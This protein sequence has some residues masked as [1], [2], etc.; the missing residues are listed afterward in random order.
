MQFDKSAFILHSKPTQSFGAFGLQVNVLLFLHFQIWRKRSKL[1]AALAES[2]PLA[3]RKFTNHT[4]RVRI[5]KAN[6]Q[7]QLFVYSWQMSRVHL[8]SFC[9][10]RQQ[11][12][13]FF[14]IVIFQ[15]QE[16]LFCV[17]LEICLGTIWPWCLLVSLALDYWPL[18]VESWSYYS[19]V[20]LLGEIHRISIATSR[21]PTLSSQSQTPFAVSTVRLLL[22]PDLLQKTP[23]PKKFLVKHFYTS[24]SR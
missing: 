10:S 22:V 13:T 6:V 18:L 20:T 19:T 2:Q 21:S 17:L 23:P 15:T 4:A 24:T 8:E 7:C 9:P 16:M 14:E 3:H 5:F 11:E 1:S 12:N